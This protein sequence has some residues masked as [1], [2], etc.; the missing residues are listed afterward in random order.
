M[1][2][3]TI[4]LMLLVLLLVTNVI[5]NY[6]TLLPTALI[7]IIVG[8]IFA[9]A[10][11]DF[12]IEVETEWFLLLFIA[13]LLYNEGAHFPREELWKMRASIFGNA[14]ILVLLTTILGGIFVHWM[15]PAIP[16]A[17]AFAL[18]AILS[19]TDPVAVNGIAKR[20]QI[21]THIMNLVRGESLIND[22]SGLV[23]F[24]YAVLA[25]V[26]GYFSVQ[27]ATGDFLY[28]F[29]VGALLGIGLGLSI[30][31]L[32]YVLRRGGF[33]DVVF[34]SLLQVL[35]PFIIFFIA[36]EM[37]HASGVI[38][39]VAAGIIHALVRERTENFR[40]QEQV[41]TDNLWSII[42]F[43]LNGLIFLLLGLTLPSAMRS[44]LENEQM[45]NWL[46]LGYVLALGFVVLGIRFLWSHTINH[47][48]Y[49]ILKNVTEKPSLK[50]SLITS[51]VGV[52]GTITMVGVLSIPFF[53][54]TNDLFPERSLI[55]FLAAGVILLTLIMATI[56]L[57]ILSKGETSTHTTSSDLT[58]EKQ[59][60]IMGAIQKINS[61]KTEENASIVY[62]LLNDYTL[63]LHM[64]RSKNK[65]EEELREYNEQLKMER[66]HS[67][68]L[69]RQ[70]TEE[71]MSVH[72]VKMVTLKSIE[73]SVSIREK[74][75]TSGANHF[76][77]QRFYQVLR[78]WKRGRLSDRELEQVQEMEDAVQIFTFEKVLAGLEERASIS[79][80][81]EVL[82]N[83]IYYYKRLL[84]KK[85]LPHKVEM[86]QSILDEQK[87]ILCLN[88]IEV[89][90]KE[91]SE[92]F[93]DG[94]ISTVEA[95]EL[96]RF[97]NYMESVVLYEYVE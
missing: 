3:L 42:A 26:T 61:E 79:E 48:D 33:V 82:H 13:P 55:I 63:M 12:T 8:L 87:E 78:D 30:N 93:K 37:F 94:A 19:P 39:V 5:G 45:S 54:S 32:R 84:N 97:V 64:L 34:H 73:K 92:M 23:A 36:E 17:A 65:N 60:M 85:E 74:A 58:N 76:I 10:V 4:I 81:P 69:E 35:T 83:M 62:E 66:L 7:Q 72:Q 28:M 86:D 53:T 68:M 22:A 43:V 40:A 56:F 25:V 80:Q 14:I 11:K 24:N 21:P 49:Y 77:R 27:K 15:I 51:L 16:L 59:R 50:T 71:Y 20:I 57:P 38:A 31:L 89:Q 2:L 96:R 88:A 47:F 95:K 18:A 46:L 44:L 91:I 6:V 29:I 75:A 52:R 9:L 67:L 41:L 1:E 70:Y 90:R